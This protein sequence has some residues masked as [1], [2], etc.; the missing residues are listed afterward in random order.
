[1]SVFEIVIGIFMVITLSFGAILLCLTMLGSN[2][3]IR[4]RW[5]K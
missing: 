5:F 3:E 4:K 1:M 2:E